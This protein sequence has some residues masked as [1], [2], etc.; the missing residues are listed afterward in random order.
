MLKLQP[1]AAGANFTS[2][3]LEASKGTGHRVVRE[4]SAYFSYATIASRAYRQNR[5]AP[6]EIHLFNGLDLWFLPH[7]PFGRRINV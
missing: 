2:G 6:I 3:F 7:L 1:N 5:D 4:K